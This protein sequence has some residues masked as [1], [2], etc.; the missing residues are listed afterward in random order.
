MESNF[1]IK[2]RS[3]IIERALILEK[4]SSEVLKILLRLI[5]VDTKTLSN[6]SSSLS[7][8]NKI[9]LLYDLGAITKDQHNYFGK[10][11]ELRNQF[12]HNIDCSSYLDF[13]K[14]NPSTYKYIQ[15]KFPNEDQSFASS[16][17]ELYSYCEKCLNDLHIEYKTGHE[18]EIEKLITNELFKNIESIIENSV[19]SW[20]EWIEGFDE[21]DFES[22]IE[23]QKISK[24][25][26]KRIIVLT[27]IN[28]RSQLYRAIDKMNFD[29]LKAS[30]NARIN[31]DQ[32]TEYLEMLD[33]KFEYV[34]ENIFN[35]I[36]IKIEPFNE[37][38]TGTNNM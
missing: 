16:L 32:L 33:K 38:M 14:I 24:E 36:E 10:F 21:Y 31:E 17:K 27:L 5:Y 30:L 4:L 3:R 35:D 18:Y 23:K 19:N 28:K 22:E 25:G 12:A 34:E 8:K 7:F 2:L 9:D 13:Q 20:E 11:M 1:N 15:S 6:K 37:Q 26:L 29:Q